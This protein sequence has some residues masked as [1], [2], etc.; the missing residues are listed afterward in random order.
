[1]VLGLQK[2]KRKE[3]IR[4]GTGKG[5]K[6]DEK[7]HRYTLDGVELKSATTLLGNFTGGFNAVPISR[8]LAEANRKKG[9][10]FLIDEG[11]IRKYWNLLG[12]LSAN[13]GTAGHQ[14]CE[15]YWINPGIVDDLHMGELFT[16]CKRVMDNVQKKYEIVEMEQSRG[17]R[18]YLIGYTIDVV[19]RHRESGVYVIGDFKFSGK[20]TPEQYKEK[21][22]RVPSL[23]EGNFKGF[24]NIGLHKGSLQLELYRRLY[25]I[26]TGRRAGSMILIHIDGLSKWYGDK[27]YKVYQTLNAEKEIN[28]LLSEQEE[29]KV[30][31]ND[32][33]DDI[34]NML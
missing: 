33:A 24:R 19:L 34:I 17:N 12:N 15:A 2:K 9:K 14:F 4:S 27:G 28:Y 21:K 31:G 8:R 26:D 18:K 10:E 30:V 32:V 23:M 13:T 3:R 11:D 29:V 1:M 25:E 20:F 5:F 16:N 6:F 7:L 22:G